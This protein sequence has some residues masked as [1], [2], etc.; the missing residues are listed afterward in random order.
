MAKPFIKQGARPAGRQVG[1]AS[2][3]KTGN[4]VKSINAHV[5]ASKARNA[6]R[7]ASASR[8]SARAGGGGGSH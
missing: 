5:A 4:Q 7:Q 2:A 3:P 1:N 8:A 6:A